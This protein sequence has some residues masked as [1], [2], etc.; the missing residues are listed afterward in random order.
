MGDDRYTACMSVPLDINW[1]N[2]R[3]AA[4]SYPDEAFEFVSEGL[5]YTVDRIHEERA[6]AE[7]E[8]AMSVGNHVSGQEL[9]IGLRDFA[10]K[11]YG[12]LA[13]IVLRRWNVNRTADF[14]QIVFAMI[15]C[16]LMSKNESDSIEDF[17]GIFDFHEAF[18]REEIL[19]ALSQN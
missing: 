14:G 5:G 7:L 13:P 1:E 16:G 11:Q 8:W 10:I 6:N 17:H 3:A 4:G 2:L 18:A 15:E 19:S 12:L 9:C